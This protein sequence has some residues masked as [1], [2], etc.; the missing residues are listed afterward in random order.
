MGTVER[1]TWTCVS[2]SAVSS[3]WCSSSWCWCSWLLRACFSST[4]KKLG[5]TRDTFCYRVPN[6][7]YANNLHFTSLDCQMGG[8]WS[9]WRFEASKRETSGWVPQWV[10]SGSENGETWTW[11][12]ETYKLCRKRQLVVWVWSI[13]CDP[14]AGTF[15]AH[16]ISQSFS[17]C[18]SHTTSYTQASSHR[19][20]NNCFRCSSALF[21]ILT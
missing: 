15:L 18:G 3:S 13:Y 19:T 6:K 9:E 1:V 4:N 21:D 14:S 7:C 12:D 16:L 8:A 2:V 10:G 5:H 20:Q 17:K 11:A